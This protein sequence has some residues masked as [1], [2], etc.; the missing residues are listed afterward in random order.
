MNPNL[1]I[2]LE[3][4]TSSEENLKKSLSKVIADNLNGNLRDEKFAKMLWVASQTI[5][6]IQ[7]YRDNVTKIFWKIRHHMTEI[8]KYIDLNYEDGYNG[9]NLNLSPSV[10]SDLERMQEY[11]IT[12]EKELNKYLEKN[13]SWTSEKPIYGI[14]HE[15]YA[16]T[17]FIYD[18]H[19]KNNGVSIESRYMYSLAEQVMGY[20]VAAK[21]QLNDIK[22][23]IIADRHY[24][25]ISGEPM[26]MDFNPVNYRFNN[27]NYQQPA[28]DVPSFGGPVFPPVPSNT[29]FN[30][31]A[32][33]HYYQNVYSEDSQETKIE[34]STV[35]NA[36][37]QQ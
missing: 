26:L 10:R 20:L 37:E 19:M 27:P 1:E 13:G 36:T 18:E 33:K 22:T 34:Q 16:V 31:N 6:T 17:S 8:R 32:T 28:M 29:G 12:L 35:S 14:L 23:N 24:C 30:P 2:T 4:D 25:S 3:L 11:G 5:S 9:V 21:A 15:I 7:H